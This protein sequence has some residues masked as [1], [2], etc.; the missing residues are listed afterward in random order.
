MTNLQSY[1]LTNNWLHRA[2]IGL[3]AST[4]QLADNHDI[5]YLKSY[6]DA[7]VMEA[8]EAEEANKSRFELEQHRPVDQKF[9]K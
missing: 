3:S 2:H 5:L 7:K 8:E 9:D 4:G 6:S 1:G